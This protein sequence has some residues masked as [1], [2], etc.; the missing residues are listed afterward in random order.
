MSQRTGRLALAALALSFLAAACAADEPATP[1][2]NATPNSEPFVEQATTAP[3]LATTP[4]AAPTTP[5]PVDPGRAVQ[6]GDTISVHYVG[7]LD[8]GEPFDS[9]R[10]RGQV[11]TFEV[12]AGR[13]IAGFDEAV[14]GMRLGELKDVRIAPVDAYGEWSQDRVI[15]V[16]LADLPEGTA[17]GDLLST[18]SGQQVSV[19]EVGE[20][21]AQID[22]NHPL[23][24]EASTSRSS[25]SQSIS[26]AS[27][28][29][30]LFFRTVVFPRARTCFRTRGGV[31][32][33]SRSLFRGAAQLD[34]AVSVASAALSAAVGSAAG[35]SSA[36][37]P[38]LRIFS[39][40]LSVTIACF[41]AGIRSGSLESS[42]ART[43]ASVR[44]CH[45]AFF[46]PTSLATAVIPPTIRASFKSFFKVPPLALPAVYECPGGWNPLRSSW[47]GWLFDRL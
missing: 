11:L 29:A 17:V 7:T 5:V 32:E 4:T 43:S 34:S 39:T 15:S 3:P 22:T 27:S 30:G 40:T 16:A 47:P 33:R 41:S 28:V 25:W 24:G 45:S 2:Q 38:R 20:T 46:A 19:L 42:F 37:A 23:A 31:Y 6:P 14:R 12:A 26:P 21:D 10:D 44:P 8:D 36:R 18:N 9:S 1:A 13:M 35:A